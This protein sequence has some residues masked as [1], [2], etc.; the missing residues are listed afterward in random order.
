MNE[1]QLTYMSKYE[2]KRILINDKRKSNKKNIFYNLLINLP[3]S[4]IG[5]NCILFFFL[6]IFSFYSFYLL[7]HD[8]LQLMMMPFGDVNIIIIIII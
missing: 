2:S 4:K 5:L 6:F 3:S 7:T 1:I 8:L